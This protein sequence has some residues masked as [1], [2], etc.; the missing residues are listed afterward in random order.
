MELL[1]I[2]SHVK[3]EMILDVPFTAE[4]VTR[5]IARLKSRKAAGPNGFMAEHWKAG[6]DL[7]SCGHLVIECCHGAGGG[8]RCFEERTDSASL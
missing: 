4:E 7:G 3:E 6:G 1:E 5:A 8:S 2:Q